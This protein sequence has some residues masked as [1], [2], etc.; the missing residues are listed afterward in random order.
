MRYIVQLVLEGIPPHK[1]DKQGQFKHTIG[2]GKTG[3]DIGTQTAAIVSDTKVTLHP[4]APRVQ[5]FEE[6]KRRIQRR[7]DRSTRAMNPDRFHPDRT[8]KQGKHTPWVRSKRYMKDLFRLKE[9]CRKQTA[10]R[11]QDHCSC[12]ASEENN[13]RRKD[14]KNKAKETVWQVDC[15]PGTCDVFSDCTSKTGVS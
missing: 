4:L 14:R 12:T 2:Q 6:E 10:I 15:A 7:M 9:I 1:L 13:C 5:R 3:C 11:K 8:V